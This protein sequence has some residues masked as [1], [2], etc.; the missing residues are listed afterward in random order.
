MEGERSENIEKMIDVMFNVYEK[1]FPDYKINQILSECF[2]LQLLR[3]KN[4]KEVTLND[5]NYLANSILKCVNNKAGKNF[6]LTGRP[7]LIISRELL[8]TSNDVKDNVV[9]AIADIKVRFPEFFEGIESR[10]GTLYSLRGPKINEMVNLYVDAIRKLVDSN[11]PDMICFP[12]LFCPPQGSLNPI[13]QL[14]KENKLFIVAGSDHNLTEHSNVG[15]IISPSG[16]IYTQEKFLK[17][18]VEGIKQKSISYLKIFDT[19]IGQFTV[20]ICL[21]IEH[22]KLKEILVMKKDI[23][24]GVD[25]ILNPSFHES[26]DRA[27]S[28]LITLAENVYAVGVFA[29]GHE[30]G[31]SFIFD[32]SQNFF[33]SNS[34]DLVKSIDVKGMRNIRYSKQNCKVNP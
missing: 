1:I 7:L 24:E 18:E 3:F 2:K 4:R 13:I 19:D 6:K 16:K 20:P 9:L 14:A 23:C 29:N 34:H 31:G 10:Y 12:E 21:D 25:F 27:N 17:S 15:V 32:L 22:P 33:N 30:R 26:P 11:P 8:R 28:M 5:T